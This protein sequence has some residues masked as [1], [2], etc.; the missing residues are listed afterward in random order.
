[1]VKQRLVV[2]G[3][4]GHALS[5]GESAKSCGFIVEG[6]IDISSDDG[7]FDSLV[8]ALRAIDLP[9]VHLALGLG[10]NPLRNKVHDAIVRS[11]PSA[12]FPPII[13]PSA[14]VSPSALLSDGVVLLAHAHAGAHA[15][16]GFGALLNVGASVDHESTLGNFASLGPGARTGGHVSIGVRTMIGLQA[17]VLQGRTVGEDS[18]IG[19]NSIVTE[20]IPSLSVAMGTP[21]RVTRSRT[22]D[23]NYY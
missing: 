1:M 9:S 2:V 7:G 23:E 18:V 20:N 19:A 6:V 3:D 10:A 16:L 12:R 22:W 17:G 13:H 15:S 11:F 8:S 4:S 21:C 5:V 14:W